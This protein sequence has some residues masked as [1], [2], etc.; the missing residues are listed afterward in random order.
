MY[1][2]DLEDQTIERGRARSTE[3]QLVTDD[4]NDD[5]DVRARWCQWL[6]IQTDSI[7][8]VLFVAL[9]TGKNVWRRLHVM[10]RQ[11][12]QTGDSHDEGLLADTHL[13]RTTGRKIKEASNQS[14]D[15]AIFSSV[16]SYTYL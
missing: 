7:T 8:L 9:C 13:Y 2:D 3:A 6:K 11:L 15:S 14:P 10:K 16:I 1:D 5:D 4:N 12:R